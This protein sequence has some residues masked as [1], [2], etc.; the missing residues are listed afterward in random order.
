M[1]VLSAV[2]T[3]PNVYN[4][5]NIIK[6]SFILH[7]GPG[8]CGVAGVHGVLS[9]WQLLGAPGWRELPFSNIMALR[10]ALGI[11]VQALKGWECGAGSLTFCW[12]THR[13]RYL[14]GKATG[15]WDLLQCSGSQFH[16]TIQNIFPCLVKICQS[17]FLCWDTGQTIIS[18]FKKNVFSTFWH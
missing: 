15:I 10:V 13:S 17:I 9:S 7:N 4:G 8:W 18:F 5:V 6:N 12:L 14:T 3:D 16:D 1:C 11:T 2:V